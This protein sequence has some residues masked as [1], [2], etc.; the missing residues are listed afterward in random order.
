MNREEQIL[1]A[2]KEYAGKKYRNDDDRAFAIKDFQAGAHWTDDNPKS[3]WISVEDRLPE[4]RHEG[5][6]DLV[7]AQ[8]LALQGKYRH[9]YI[10]RYDYDCEIW[11]DITAR[12]RTTPTYW[13]PIPKLPNV[14][15]KK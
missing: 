1:A 13:M 12:M 15:P 5:Y 14:E 9:L 3:P 6:S 2:A 11:I 4:E 10:A 7:L 8:R